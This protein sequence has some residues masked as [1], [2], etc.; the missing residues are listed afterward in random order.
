MPYN[1]IVIAFISYKSKT[2]CGLD[3]NM[4]IIER[5]SLVSVDL[6]S[7]GR[8][9]WDRKRKTMGYYTKLLLLKKILKRASYACCMYKLNSFMLQVYLAFFSFFC[10]A[11]LFG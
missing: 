3:Y 11:C 6:I 8:T 10:H 1:S 2:I 9:Y 4:S 5:M 7:S